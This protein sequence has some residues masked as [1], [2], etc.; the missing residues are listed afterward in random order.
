[1]LVLGDKLMLAFSP[2]HLVLKLL[3]AFNPIDLVLKLL[4][5]FNP[6]DLVLV[7]GVAS[8]VNSCWSVS[9]WA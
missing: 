6:I 5:A 8:C 4:L 2:I 1:M 7:M 3:L 9:V